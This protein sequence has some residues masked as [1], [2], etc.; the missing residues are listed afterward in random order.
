MCSVAYVGFAHAQ[1]LPTRVQRLDLKEQY[2]IVNGKMMMVESSSD[3]REQLIHASRDGDLS[4]VK[5]LVEVRHVD[6]YSCRDGEHD[7]TP[8]HWASNCGHLDV[9]RYLVEE[10]TV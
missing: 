9:V 3:L 8:L 4:K 10:R 7:A 1:F 6:P 5:Y 2:S